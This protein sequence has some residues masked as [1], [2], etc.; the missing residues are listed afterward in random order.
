MDE[1]ITRADVNRL[2]AKAFAVERKIAQQ[3][4]SDFADQLRD[5]LEKIVL[6]LTT[7]IGELNRTLAELRR[8]Q[9]APLD[10]PLPPPPHA[11]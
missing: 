9:G 6:S 1:L 11:H 4:L 10:K 8:I 2:I 7:E 3:M 5:D